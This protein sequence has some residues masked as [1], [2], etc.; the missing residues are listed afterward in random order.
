MPTYSLG[1]FNCL[2]ELQLHVARNNLWRVPATFRRGKQLQ[3]QPTGL[4]TFGPSKSS[5][6]E[7]KKHS[8]GGRSQSFDKSNRPFVG[9]FGSGGHG[10][11]NSSLGKKR[12]V[13]P[14]EQ[15]KKD[16]ETEIVCGR[17]PSKN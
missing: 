11:G 13:P 5:W 15:K 9:T 4:K 14:H 6:K 17:I 3:L 10:H 8:E 12:K 7:Q 1:K 2:S 16:S